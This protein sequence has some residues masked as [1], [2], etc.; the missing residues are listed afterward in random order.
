MAGNKRRLIPIVDRSFQYKYTGLIFGVAAVV[1]AILGFF[2]LS[3][4]REMNDLMDVS[5]AI[6]DKLNAD[7]AQRVFTMVVGFLVAEVLLLGVAGLLITHRV[8]GPVFV[9]HRHLATLLD[10]EYP[11]IRPLRANDE[12]KSTFQTFS[13]VVGMFRERDEKEIGDLEA[14]LAAAQEKG[15]SE[16][17]LATLGRLVEERR[18][19]SGNADAS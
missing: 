2:L 9:F 8:A 18:G 1:S 15:L 3:A 4:Y 5:A 16:E 17:H 14:V 19:R 12:F 6:G 13:D 7:D 10:G 11:T